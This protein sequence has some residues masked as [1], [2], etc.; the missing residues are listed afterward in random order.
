MFLKKLIYLF[1]AVAFLASCGGTDMK[2]PEEVGSRE[3]TTVTSDDAVSDLKA[4]AIKQ[5]DLLGQAKYA[6]GILQ[7][8]YNSSSETV[9]VIGEVTVSVDDNFILSIKNKVD[10]DVHEQRVSLKDL[11]S[12]LRSFEWIVDNGENPYPGVK[13]PV[14][15]GKSS[16]EKLVDGSLQSSET[17]LEI[18]HDNRKAVQVSVSG[19]MNAIRAAKG[20]ALE[21]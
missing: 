8:N 11:D 18:I 10:G 1:I 5:D 19:L 9:D 3:E 6:L 4:N 20:E 7:S 21:R 12:N 2:N 16:V 14:M 17:H 15:E 13:I